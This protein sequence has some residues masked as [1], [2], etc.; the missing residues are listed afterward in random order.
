MKISVELIKNT[1]RTFLNKFIYSQE[2]EETSILNVGNGNFLNLGNE[3]KKKYI[4]GTKISV[5]LIKTKV[6]FL[7]Q[8]FTLSSRKCKYH[9]TFSTN[10]FLNKSTFYAYRIHE[11]T[12]KRLVC[13]RLKKTKRTFYSLFYLFESKYFKMSNVNKYYKTLIFFIQIINFG[14]H[15]CFML[16][17]FVHICVS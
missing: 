8:Y 3:V 9:I 13:Y 17:K 2:F 1:L 5:E 12:F 16:S 7:K 14:K 11:N 10:H 15:R 6:T 4:L